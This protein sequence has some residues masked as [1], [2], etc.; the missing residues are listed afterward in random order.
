MEPI[1]VGIERFRKL[2][3]DIEASVDDDDTE[4]DSRLKVINRMLT[5]VL[6]WPIS[7]IKTEVASPGGFADYTARV[8]DRVRLVVE[9][10]RNRRA[11]G[12]EGRSAGRAYKVSGGVFST[13]AVKEGIGQAIQYCAEHSCELACVTNG[14]EWI[15]FRGSRLG[16][17]TPTREGLAFVFPNLASI[18]EQFSPF[19]PLLSYESA[20]T[21]AYRPYFHEAEGQ[22]IRTSVFHKSLRPRGSA[23]VISAEPLYAD[24][25]RVM[26]EYFQRLTGEGN[27]EMLEACF[28]E[29]SESQRAE[30]Q[31]VRITEDVVSLIR[32]LDTSHGAELVKLIEASGQLRRHEFVMIVGTKGA[33]KSTFLARFFTRVLSRATKESVVV[34][35]TDLSKQTG[36]YGTLTEWLNREI[37]RQIESTLF[38]DSAPSFEELQGMFFDEYKRLVKG[39]WKV[40]YEKDK[41]EFQVKFG[42]RI[43]TIRAERSG[44]YIAGLL[45]HVINSRERLPVLVFDNADHFDIAFQQRVYQFA[46]SIYEQAACLVIL[47]ITDRTSWQLSKEGALQS[48]ENEALFLPAPKTEDVIRKR[49]E[50]LSE[51]VELQKVTP[52]DRYG[53]T[54]NISISLEDL[55]KFSQT[56]QQVFLQDSTTSNWIGQLANYNVRRTLDLAKSLVSSPHLKVEDLVNAYL[57]GTTVQVPDFRSVNA[58]IKQKYDI[59][60]MGQNEYVQNLFALNEDLVTTPLLGLRILQLLADVPRDER[61]AALLSVD[62][63][64][65]Y[66]AGMNIESRATYLWL[67]SLLDDQLVLNYDPTVT[68]IKDATQVEI[69]PSGRLHLHWAQGNQDYLSAMSAVTPLLTEAVYAD[70]SRQQ[71]NRNWRAATATFIDYLV[72][73]DKTYCLPPDHESYQSQVRVSETLQ[74]RAQRLREWRPAQRESNPQRGGRSRRKQ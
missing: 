72:D 14:R 68:D 1:D 47:P 11:L 18:E 31:L 22:P 64:I 60:P 17:G 42:E 19:F 38:D 71:G 29:S 2:R 41:V 16:D 33:G 65:T 20:G 39:S 43:E 63:L 7:S 13:E 55:S 69:S 73:E 30:R 67:Q 50:Y 15:I 6:F 74:R 32:E 57:S 46:R 66:C 44:E 23:H 4:A 8:N 3:P 5:E 25:E 51:L 49:I 24:L 28:V 48:F 10:K 59:Y 62:D 9:A 58:L 56:L 53:I 27:E 21:F 36:D 26:G 52:R 35:R 61:R 12:T 34:V 54:R 70:L 45:R 37:I 40:L